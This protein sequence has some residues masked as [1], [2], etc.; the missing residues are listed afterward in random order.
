MRITAVGTARELLCITESVVDAL[1]M[2]RNR[3]DIT[4]RGQKSDSSF[5]TLQGG[6]SND[7]EDRSAGS[8][9][10]T[11]SE[12]LRRS[13]NV[14]AAFVVP[15]SINQLSSS[16][17]AAGSVH[18]PVKVLR[19]VPVPHNDMLSCRAV[20]SR[21]NLNARV[22]SQIKPSHLLNADYSV[23]DEATGRISEKRIS[24]D[25]E[26][27]N[28]VRTELTCNNARARNSSGSG[29]ATG[30]RMRLNEFTE[31]SPVHPM[32]AILDCGYLTQPIHTMVSEEKLSSGDSSHST[33]MATS[34]SPIEVLAKDRETS[35][36]FL[37]SFYSVVFILKVSDQALFKYSAE[38]VIGMVDDN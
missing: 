26:K 5:L 17:E 9:S 4:N 15:S 34:A 2:N 16:D 14:S 38:I 32:V 24:Q 3:S 37:F 31:S 28:Y 7:I 12:I 25:S 21:D 30:D 11:A 8:Q 13:T 18:V 29:V 19:E 22:S 33:S 35:V 23:A 1:N 36:L 27:M 20:T 6:N 10:S